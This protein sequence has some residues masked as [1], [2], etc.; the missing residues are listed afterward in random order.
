MPGSKRLKKR[1]RNIYNNHPPASPFAQ[2]TDSDI[3][4]RVTCSDDSNISYSPMAKSQLQKQSSNENKSRLKRLSCMKCNCVV[5][6]PTET[7]ISRGNPIIS[8]GNEEDDG[9]SYANSHS[10]VPAHTDIND[11]D[12]LSYEDE[13]LSINS[14][15][16]EPQCSPRSSLRF[17][18]LRT[19]LCLFMHIPRTPTFS[20]RRRRSYYNLKTLSTSVCNSTKSY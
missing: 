3:I 7:I 16:N 17:F 4:S 10:R 19:T 5:T 8:G 15:W 6:E 9:I 20:L 14:I 13:D 12:L 1:I 11:D 18:L 2:K